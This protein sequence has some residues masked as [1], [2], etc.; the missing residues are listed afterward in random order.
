MRDRLSA[1]LLVLWMLPGCV[2]MGR[3]KALEGQL[4]KV[5]GDLKTAEYLTKSARD[6]QRI[7]VKDTAC[8]EKVR[9]FC[10]YPHTCKHKG[11]LR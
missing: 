11:M 10:E 3:Y 7:E 1:V 5:Q 9:K 8:E 4:V 6:V 2:S